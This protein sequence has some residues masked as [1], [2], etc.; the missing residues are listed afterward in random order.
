MSDIRLRDGSKLHPLLEDILLSRGI[1]DHQSI[2][3]FLNPKLS[4]LPDPFLLKDMDPAAGLICDALMQ[5]RDFL[6]WGDYDV[7]GTTATALLVK[8][9]ALLGKEAAYHIP[10][11]LTEG[12]GLQEKGL[13]KITENRIPEKCILITVDNGISAHRAVNYARELG[14]TVIVTDHHL[15]GAKRVAAHAVINPNQKDCGFPDKNMAG[16]GIAFYLAMAVRSRLMQAGYFTESA[17]PNLKTLLDLVAIGTVADMV[18]LGE[19]NRVL[20]KAGLE[21][22]A[23]GGNCGL[24]ALCRKTNIDPGFLRSEDISF[25]L[26]PKINAA[27]RLGDAQKA[28][29]L[30]LASSKSEAALLAAQLVA[31]NEIRKD[32][33]MRDFAHALDELMLAG[34]NKLSVT[35]VVAG[36][37][38][39][40]V[41]GIVASKLVEKFRKPAV[42]LC[43]TEDGEFKGSARSVQGVDLYGAL[44]DCHELLLG[45]G[46]H[47][48]AGGMSM[49]PENLSDFKVLFNDAVKKQGTA[50]M[51]E[52]PVCDADI[53]AGALFSGQ[54]LRQ[55]H[56]MEPFGQGN[57]QLIFRDTSSKFLQLSQIGKD[58]NHLRFSLQGSS[59]NVQGVAFG[60]GEDFEKCLSNRQREIFYTPSVNF[61]R[62]K[63]SWQVR[64]TGLKF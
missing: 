26:A 10:N 38:H 51:D 20:V 22:I 58:K 35:T 32:I 27:G 25:Q 16:V 2:V 24:T 13:K 41:A 23:G 40:G 60:F 33:T 52:V 62:G 43:E 4:D 11:R 49:L 9:F 44:A 17:P 30:F 36:A 63:R 18:V 64:V 54:L 45:F 56:M 42:V 19:V 57:P 29:R 5:D 59:R 46:G 21:V 47:K 55:I 7:D 39:V 37:Y 12:Y 14:Y 61:F 50:E 31:N 6:I 53:E 8:F 15:S 28:V 48:M 3:E 1:C 34:E